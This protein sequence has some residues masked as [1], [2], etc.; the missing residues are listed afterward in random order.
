MVHVVDSPKAN[1]T[2]E[3]EPQCPQRRELIVRQVIFS[4]LV[5]RLMLCGSRKLWPAL[6]R[7]FSRV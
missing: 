2:F 1:A 6:K 7:F 4:R 3:L 5:T